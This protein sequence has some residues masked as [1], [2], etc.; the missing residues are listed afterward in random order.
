MIEISE[1]MSY[2]VHFIRTYSSQAIVEAIVDILLD[3][4]TPF[5]K[6]VIDTG[7]FLFEVE[8]F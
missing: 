6:A 4:D 7:D 8:E 1:G 5:G 2:E 3:D